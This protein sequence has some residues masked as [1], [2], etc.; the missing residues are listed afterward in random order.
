MY[1]IP[2]SSAYCLLSPYRSLPLVLILPTL[3]HDLFCPTKLT[4]GKGNIVQERR[5]KNWGMSS[6][7]DTKMLKPMLYAA[8]VE[9][10]LLLPR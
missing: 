8:E 5:E 3:K 2:A 10:P 7:N 9:S 6:L 4:K 1:E